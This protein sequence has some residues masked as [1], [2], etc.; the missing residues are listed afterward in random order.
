[1][2]IWGDGSVVRDYIYVK[3]VVK[4]IADLI[5]KIILNEIIN[6]G[7]GKGYSINNVIKL[8]QQEI[9][10]FQLKY[11]DARKVDIPHLVLDINKLEKIINLNLTSIEE[12]IKSTYKWL[13]VL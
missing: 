8:I 11:K 4:I 12:G 6:I 1:M 9:G 2:E 10:N 7:S 5:E 3:D 13:K